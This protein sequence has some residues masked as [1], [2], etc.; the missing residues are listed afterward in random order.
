MRRK[1]PC[2]GGTRRTGHHR[3]DRHRDQCLR[4]T[5]ILIGLDS[6]THSLFGLTVAR[7]PLRRAGR[8]VT[9]A[10]VLASNAPDIDILT[11]IGGAASYLN[12]HRGPTHGPLGIVGL[13][14]VCALI[15]R[16][17]ARWRQPVDDPPASIFALWLIS[18]IGV[19]CHVLMDLPTSYGTRPLSPFSWTW[20]VEDWMPIVDIYLIGI[21][22]GGL[23]LGRRFTRAGR[24][25]RARAA[26]LALALMGGNYAMRATLHHI[27]LTV[28]PAVFGAHLAER[29]ADAVNEGAW[30]DHY[31]RAGVRS[32]RDRAVEPCLVEVAA[33]PDFFSPFRWQ[34]IA[35]LSNAYERRDV[36]L[37]DAESRRGNDLQRL[38]IRYPN[39]WTPSVELAAQSRIGRIY[40]GFSRFPAA[41][42]SVDHQ[43]VTT[44]RWTDIRF[45]A[46]SLA[47]PDRGTGI[48][49]ATVR[50]AADG[51]VLDQRLGASHPLP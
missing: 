6:L 45:A 2:V 29:C 17:A 8:G 12:W 33:I 19:C 18:M 32:P 40:L 30:L 46:N 13:S 14:L 41:R 42:S 3:G 43:G 25:V 22:G 10:L 16:A 47:A 34:L 7:T 1:S 15:A 51:S 48:F 9:V 44:V 49:I 35:E 37:L 21:L 38:S 36:N 27:A 20:F 50:I 31:P 39:Q 5:A 23:L 4:H 24:D 26:A 11:A 28:A